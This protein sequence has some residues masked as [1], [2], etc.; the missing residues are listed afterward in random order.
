MRALPLVLVGSD[1]AFAFRSL[2]TPYPKVTNCFT[3]WV[4]LQ[5]LVKEAAR[6]DKPPSLRDSLTALGFGIVST[7]VGSV[8]K[9]HSAG[10][11][12]VRTAAVLASMSLRGAEQEVLPVTFTWCR[13]WYWEAV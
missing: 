6:L 11:D 3:Y 2:S 10:K 4:D 13:K 1:L 9:K 12:T 7:D 5:Q 8:W